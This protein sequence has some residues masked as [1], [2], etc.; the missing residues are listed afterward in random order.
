MQQLLEYYMGK[1]TPARQEFIVKN[2]R[3]EKEEIVAELPEIAGE[4]AD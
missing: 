1:N 3:F 2:L 4:L